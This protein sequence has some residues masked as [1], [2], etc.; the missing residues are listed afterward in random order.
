M[1]VFPGRVYLVSSW[2]CRYEVQKRLGAL[3]MLALA[4]SAFANILAYGIIQI[5]NNTTYKGGA[6]YILLRAQ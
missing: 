5:A 2:Y 1:G 6:G 4:L 3:Y